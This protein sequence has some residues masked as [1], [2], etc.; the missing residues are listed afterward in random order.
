MVVVL[1][2]SVKFGCLEF[3]S[4][5]F[6]IVGSLSA[7][8]IFANKAQMLLSKWY[9]SVLDFIDEADR[10]SQ[11]ETHSIPVMEVKPYYKKSSL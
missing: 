6:K 3:I 4:F 11:Q 1:A 8:L 10:T 7:K 2:T 9:F 5:G